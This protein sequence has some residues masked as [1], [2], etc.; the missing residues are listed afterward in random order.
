MYQKSDFWRS[1]QRV[2][3]FTSSW[4]IPLDSLFHSV[5]PFSGTTAS[6]SRTVPSPVAVVEKRRG[7][8]L[9]GDPHLKAKWEQAWPVSLCIIEGSRTHRRPHHYQLCLCGVGSHGTDVFIYVVPSQNPDQVQ[10]QC[11]ISCMENTCRRTQC[12][13][14]LIPYAFAIVHLSFHRASCASKIKSLYLPAV[15][16]HL[17]SNIIYGLYISTFM[18][19]ELFVHS[20]EDTIMP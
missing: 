11:S 3:L 9:G 16:I 17:V 18:C 13:Q 7:V 4:P 1:I 8:L 10:C 15:W 12:S 14:A 6:E 20:V 2:L 19:S 5:S